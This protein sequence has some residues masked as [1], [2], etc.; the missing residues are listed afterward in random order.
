M[1]K[2]LIVLFGLFSASLLVSQSLMDLFYSLI[3]ILSVIHIF[4]G[5][6]VVTTDPKFKFVDYFFIAWISVV[7]IGLTIN[8]LEAPLVINKISEFKWIV[9]FLILYVLLREIDLSEKVLR[10]VYYFLGFIGLYSASI[11]F[12]GFDPIKGKDFIMTPAAGGVRTGGFFS[13]AM[14]YAHS[15]G[16]AFCL[17]FGVGLVYL[18]TKTSMRWLSVVVT[19][20]LGLSILLTF[21]RGVWGSLFIAILF[22]S[23]VWSRPFF[24]KMSLALLVVVGGAVFSWQGLQDRITQTFDQSRSYDGERVYLWKTNWNIFKDYPILGIGYG[25]NKR[26]LPEYYAKQNAP[27][28]QFQGHAHN[29]YLH[30]LAGTGLVGLAFYLVFL[31]YIYKSSLMA[32]SRYQNPDWKKGLAVGCLG[33]VVHLILGGI[34]ESNFEHSKIKYFVAFLMALIFWLRFSEPQPNKKF[35]SN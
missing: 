22:M 2:A 11:F 9:V 28:G 15:A 17:S 34:F 16:F 31:G 27:E 25:E 32:I 12:L 33:A 23:F 35:L 29:Q 13:N 8:G 14:T 10:P 30:F 18:K 4:R 7:L 26:R 5:H 20:L 3:L 19:G 21:T 1:Q 6:L 24:Y